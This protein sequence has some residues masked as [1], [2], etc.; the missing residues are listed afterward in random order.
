MRLH[1]SRK[2]ERVVSRHGNTPL[3]VGEVSVFTD[4][5]P[6]AALEASPLSGLCFSLF[7][8]LFHVRN[9][10]ESRV[11]ITYSTKFFV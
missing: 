2:K 11:F 6:L 4:T 9:V 8:S 7:S 5:L 10:D 1:A 3:R